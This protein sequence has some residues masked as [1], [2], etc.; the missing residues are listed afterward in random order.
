MSSI[1]CLSKA[2]SSDDLCLTAA[3]AFFTKVSERP[4]SAL[5]WHVRHENILLHGK[6]RA[7][8]LKVASSSNDAPKIAAFD[9]DGTLI[10]TK[11]GNRFARD[12]SDWRFFDKGVPKR[13]QELYNTGHHIVIFTNQVSFYAV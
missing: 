1:A 4:K 13:L 5:S 10:A 7:C 8:D 11:S 2:V 6:Y 12:E 9:L 3:S